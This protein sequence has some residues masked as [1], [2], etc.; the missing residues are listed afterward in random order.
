M[1][2]FIELILNFYKIPRTNIKNITV[3]E[4]LF[5]TFQIMEKRGCHDKKTNPKR[6]DNGI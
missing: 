4:Q 2:T 6:D 1:I 5:N 3:K